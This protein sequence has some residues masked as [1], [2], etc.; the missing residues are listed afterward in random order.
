MII[1]LKLEPNSRAR[2]RSTIKTFLTGRFHV[3]GSTQSVV[4][5][6]TVLETATVQDIRFLAEEQQFDPGY[7]STHTTKTDETSGKP[8]PLPKS[9][10]SMHDWVC[11][12]MCFSIVVWYVCIETVSAPWRMGKQRLCF[13]W[14]KENSFKRQWKH[15]CWIWI[16]Q[17][18]SRELVIV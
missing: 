11:V 5:V 4:Q 6:N 3:T 12:Y 14:F 10:H 13:T 9:P 18:L 17:C 16:S 15:N 1:H 7:P 8:W 2:W